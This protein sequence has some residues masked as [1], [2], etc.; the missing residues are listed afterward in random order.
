MK[1]QE[2]HKNTQKVKK[3]ICSTL[4]QILITLAANDLYTTRKDNTYHSQKPNVN[5]THANFFNNRFSCIVF[6]TNEKLNNEYVS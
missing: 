2:S 6:N 3:S 4:R 1:T 5:E